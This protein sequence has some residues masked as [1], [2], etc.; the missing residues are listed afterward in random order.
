MN[1]PA[2]PS[3]DFSVAKAQLSDL[4]NAVFHAHQPHL[5]SRHHG[6]E[7]MLLVRPED[8]LLML[9]DQRIEVEAIYDAGEVTLTT[10]KLGVLGFGES[11][12][13][14]LDDLLEELRAYVARFFAEPQRYLMAGRGSHAG[15]LLRFA[16][17]RVDGQRELLVQTERA[18]AHERV[19]TG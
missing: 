11:L 6:K 5:I 1:E 16:L 19:G 8:V 2:V 15:A 3:T 17:T 18:P 4:M 13:E 10:P 12:E 7:R 14:A 9:G